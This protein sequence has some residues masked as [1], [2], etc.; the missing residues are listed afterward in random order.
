M[1]LEVKRKNVQV[2]MQNL[3]IKFCI[4][5][6]VTRERSTLVTQLHEGISAFIYS[7]VA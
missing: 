6:L 7:I 1:F 4:R 2:K 5:Y 3:R